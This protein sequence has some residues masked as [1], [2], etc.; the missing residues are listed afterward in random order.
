MGNL[1]QKAARNILI[2]VM[3]LVAILFVLSTTSFA[4][5]HPEI[6]ACVVGVFCVVS[7]IGGVRYGRGAD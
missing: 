4:K 5:E 6:L 1:S 7:L 3:I 2:V